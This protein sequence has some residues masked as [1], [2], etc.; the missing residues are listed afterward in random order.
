MAGGKGSRMQ[1]DVHKQ[2][3]K[4]LMIKPILYYTLKAFEGIC[5]FLDAL[6]IVCGK[7]EI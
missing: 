2:Y 3:N 4:R 1:S 5:G 7:G 6:I